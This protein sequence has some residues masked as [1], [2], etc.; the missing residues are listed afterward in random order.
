MNIS[1]VRGT[2]AGMAVVV[3]LMLS[4]AP[5]QAAASYGGP[6]ALV[7]PSTGRALRSGGSSTTWAIKLP[8]PPA[9]NCSGDSARDAHFV[10]SY[11][12]PAS[13]SPARLTFNPDTGVGAVE[14]E[15][16]FP[17]IDNFGRP[18]ISRNAAP[19][20]GQ[21]LPGTGFTFS[22]LSLDGAAGGELPP[23]TYNVG[24]ACWNAADRKLD[25]YWTATVIFKQSD[26]D[27]NGLVWKTA[28]VQVP[29][30]GS[31][32]SPLAIAAPVAGIALV[33][34]VALRRRAETGGRDRR[35][36]GEVERT[37]G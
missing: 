15:P 17:L 16:V 4:A 35:P 33:A 19:D 7:D 13:V 20:T 1:R 37:R 22:R 26:S 8:R 6:A 9:A 30:D 36:G 28:E 34:G 21:V 5:A 24:L 14:G 32:L 12:V 3:G 29:S 18:Y 25:K 10:Y 2:V 31:G 23:G 27:A 11:L